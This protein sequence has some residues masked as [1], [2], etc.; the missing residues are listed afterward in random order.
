MLYRINYIFITSSIIL[1]FLD[2]LPAIFYTEE[3]KCFAVPFFD[4]YSVL[5][6]IYWIF[7]R[8]IAT[9]SA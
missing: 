2:V 9:M 3:K 1:G 6:K 8:L 4:E 7:S 5:F